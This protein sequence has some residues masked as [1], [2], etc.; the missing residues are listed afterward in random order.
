[1]SRKI[2]ERICIAIFLFG[3]ANFAVFWVTALLL[4]GDAVGGKIEDG[5]YYLSSHGR[6]TKVSSGTFYY[7][8][9]HARSI[10]ITHPLALFALVAAASVNRDKKRSAT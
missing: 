3:F 8:R 4:G 10:W 7:S 6:F 1:M 5:N 9:A 2:I